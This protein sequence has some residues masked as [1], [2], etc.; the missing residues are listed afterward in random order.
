MAATMWRQLQQ[1]AANASRSRDSVKAAAGRELGSYLRGIEESE[2]TVSIGFEETDR[3]GG[4]FT[5]AANGGNA[6]IHIDPTRISGRHGVG[7]QLIL[8]HELGHAAVA[9]G[10]RG[11]AGSRAA[12]TE[13]ERIENVYR[14]MFKCRRRADH[15]SVPRC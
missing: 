7:N 11:S 2:R 1:L 5:M 15:Y 12:F 6:S 10:G 13:S 14:S 4:A 8:V 9:V 3:Y